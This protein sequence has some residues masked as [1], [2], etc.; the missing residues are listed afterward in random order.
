MRA[1][2]QSQSV[3]DIVDRN[4]ALNLGVSDQNLDRGFGL[5]LRVVRTPNP[6]LVAFDP[7]LK[8]IVWAEERLAMKL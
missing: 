4:R 6:F 2:R 5:K 3:I 8:G 1:L 7:K